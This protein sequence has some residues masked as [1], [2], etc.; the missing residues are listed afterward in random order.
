MADKTGHLNSRM[1]FFLT[2]FRRK[3]ISWCTHLNERNEYFDIWGR[4]NEKSLKLIYKTTL[5]HNAFHIYKRNHSS[6][7]LYLNL[8][9]WYTS[10]IGQ[11]KVLLAVTVYRSI[12]CTDIGFA[13]IVMCI[14]ICICISI[15][16]SCPIFLCI[17]ICISMLVDSPGFCGLPSRGPA[18][19]RSLLFPFIQPHLLHL[20][21]KISPQISN[22]LLPIHLYLFSDHCV[23]FLQQ[24]S[25]TT[26]R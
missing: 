2:K 25:T 13:C 21:E 4:R 20:K 5:L 10:Q 19:S 17:C 14:C 6:K 7:D 3:S 23:W 1:A 26:V 12:F 18:F 16:H 15:F 11:N 8:H 24:K 22:Q 9:K